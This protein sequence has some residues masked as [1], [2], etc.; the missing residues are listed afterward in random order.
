MAYVP[1]FQYDLFVSYASEDNVDGWVEKLQTRLTGELAGLLGRPFSAKTVFFDTLRLNVGQAYP[2]VLDKAARDSALL[3]TLLSPSYATSE[4]CGR[5]R[6][7]FQE[8]LPSGASFLECLATVRVRPTSALPQVL[9]D[10]QHKDFVIPESEKPWP[11]GSRRWLEIVNQLAVGIKQVLQKLRNCAGPVFVGATLPSDMQLRERIADYLSQ[12]QFRATP[13]STALLDDRAA[14]QKA[15]TEAACAVHFLGGASDAAL[16]AVED[17]IQYCLGP[18]VVFQPFGA[19]LTPTE[20]LFLKDVAAT[21]ERYPQRPGPNEIE[22][23]RFLEDLLARTKVDTSAVAAS[24]ALVCEPADFPWAEQFRAD[25]ISV[26]YPRFL[27]EKLTTTDK[28]RRWRQLVRKSHGLLFYQG[29]SEEELLETIQ[30]MAEDEK[31][32]AVRCWYLGEPNLKAKQQRRPKDPPYP[33]DLRDF[34]D[35]VRRSVAGAP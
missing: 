29:R 17:S 34:L 14:S 12:Q 26:D 33:V 19:S 23:K 35:K 15:L 9:Q 13:D 24:L 22:L 1:G 27:L 31:S 18:T 3:V 16:Q 32:R 20:E 21:A 6:R 5:E 25:G 28:I 8:H 30:R 7:V 2:E 10:A 11:V 4:W